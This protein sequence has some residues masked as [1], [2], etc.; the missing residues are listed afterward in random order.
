MSKVGAWLIEDW[1]LFGV[2]CLGFE[3]CRPEAAAMRVVANIVGKELKELLTLQ[4]LAPLLSSMLILFVVGRVMRGERAKV[5][6][7]TTMIVADRDQTAES[8]GIADVMR[9][10]NIAL[11]AAEGDSA[12][13]L[14]QARALGIDWIVVIPAGVAES[15]AAMRPVSVDVY[16]IVTSFSVSEAVR[17]FAL[18]NVLQKVN[19][20]IA[21]RRFE[22]AY[23]GSAA[24]A[25]KEAVRPREFVAVRDRVAPGNAD[26][27]MKVVFSQLFLIPIILLMILIYSSQMIAASVGQEKENKTL[28]TLLT[29]PINRANIVIGKMLGAG[30]VALIISAL[31]IGV[32]VYYT[33]SFAQGMPRAGG[34]ELGDL[35]QL[36]VGLTLQ[37]F[38]LLGVGLFLAVLCA[39][40][41]ATLLAVFADD[42][43]SAQMTVTPL[44]MLVLLP[45][46]FSMFFDLGSAS[47]AM[48]V[49]IYAIPFSYP[50]LTP[51]AVM[52]GNYGLIFA[53]YCY[54]A[55]FAATC[56]FVAARIF[57]TDRILTAKLR[58]G[59]KRRMKAEG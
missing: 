2:W 31:F 17:G 4:M 52:F 10:E 37:S 16:N 40:S 9:A 26:M 29:V 30:T 32:M 44:M 55:L 56:I 50:F 58:W 53:G 8:R 59:R 21:A 7:S 13:L 47:V 25:A 42:A 54:M 51:N 24:G 6:G 45:Y 41:L 11:V 12:D 27:L 34:A 22:R 18:K 48:K 19:E 35:A 23:P 3:V 46:F 1:V 33:G 39:L 14:K 49:L 28:E 20:R 43:K 57:A 38:L 5:S 15:V 36:D